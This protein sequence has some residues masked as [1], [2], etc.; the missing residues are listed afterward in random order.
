MYYSLSSIPESKDGG[1]FGH[2]AFIENSN[3]SG[4]YAYAEQ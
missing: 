2:S 3:W 4:I 1:D